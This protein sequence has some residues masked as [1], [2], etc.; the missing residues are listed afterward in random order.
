MRIQLSCTTRFVGPRA[1]LQ[2]DDVHF[3]L[4]V[5]VGFGDEAGDDTQRAA[6]ACISLPWNAMGDDVVLCAFL[7]V[8]GAVPRA[9]GV[10]T[11]PAEVL[12]EFGKEL[13][14]HI[15]A[16]AG[17]LAMADPRPK[18]A[19]A[20]NPEVNDGVTESTDAALVWPALIQTLANLPPPLSSLCRA[21]WY[22]KCATGNF[23][24]VTLR[25]AVLFLVPAQ[26]K[27]IK[28]ELWDE[29]TFV[30]QAPAAVTGAKCEPYQFTY[31]AMDATEASALTPGIDLSSLTDNV[32]AFGLDSYWLGAV[33]SRGT[34]LES[35][36][37]QVDKAMDADFQVK[38][39]DAS[40]I[41][42]LIEIRDATLPL[43]NERRNAL[44]AALHAF[45]SNIAGTDA[46]P[47]S[48]A[49]PAAHAKWER[50]RRE[51]IDGILLRLKSQVGETQRDRLRQVLQDRCSEWWA[52]VLIND[53]LK[54]KLTK[55][56]LLFKGESLALRDAGTLALP[57]LDHVLPLESEIRP[58]PVLPGEGIDFHVGSESNRLVHENEDNADQQGHLAEIES[59]GVLVRRSAR[60]ESL[61]DSAWRLVTAGV[62]VIDPHGT[63]LTH[64]AWGAVP[65]E[66]DLSH[67]NFAVPRG[68]GAAF[69]DGVLRNDHLYL[70]VPLAAGTALAFVHDRSEFETATDGN[71]GKQ[72]LAYLSFER[73]APIK[74]EVGP[75]ISGACAAPPLRYGDWY[76]IAG[77]VTDR[78]GGLPA[79]MAGEMPWQ[80]DFRKLPSLLPQRAPARMQFRRRVP[81]GEINILPGIGGL[82]VIRDKQ[83]K[84]DWPGLPKGVTLRARE[85]LDAKHGGSDNG[86]SLLLGNGLPGTLDDHVFSAEPPR[87]DEHT[88]QRWLMPAIGSAD[89][90][91]ELQAL[92]DE[93]TRIF[94]ARDK[95]VEGDEDEVR[96]TAD[97]IIL[98]QQLLP[99]DPAVSLVMVR[100]TRV[101][102]LERETLQL[103][104][105]PR[106]VSAEL[107]FTWKSCPI[108]CRRPAIPARSGMLDVPLAE[109]HFACIEFLPAVERDVFE[110]RMDAQALAG[111]FDPKPVE[112]LGGTY[113]LFNPSRVLVEHATRRMPAAAD[114]YDAFELRLDGRGAV[115]AAFNADAAMPNLQFVDRF[116]LKRQRW[117]WRNV[118]LTHPSI[119]DASLVSGLPRELMYPRTR[120]THENVHRFDVLATVDRGLVDRGSVSGAMPRGADSSI[121][122]A[123]D[124]FTDDR[125]AMSSADYLRFG[126][127]VRSRYAG[128]FGKEDPNVQAS[129]PGS[130]LEPGGLASWRRIVARYRGSEAD[131][132]A[133]K[134]LTVLPLTKSLELDPRTGEETTVDSSRPTPHVALL[135]ESWFREYGQGEELEARVVLVRREIGD[136]ADDR[137]PFAIGP[138]PDHYLTAANDDQDPPYYRGTM[139]T[140]AA[141]DPLPMFTLP[142]F[143]P[144]GY[145]LDRSGNEALA[146]ATAFVIFP[147][148]DVHPHWVMHVQFRRV[149]RGLHAKDDAGQGDVEVLKGPWSDTHPL[150]T[151]PDSAALCRAT[152]RNK[153]MRLKMRKGEG[154][155]F[156]LT[157]EACVLDLHPY[158]PEVPPL[159]QKQYRYLLIVGPIVSDGGRGVDIML[160]EHAFWLEDAST[161]KSL[162]TGTPVIDGQVIAGRI[163][164]VVT[165]GRYDPGQAPIDAAQSMRSLFRDHLLSDQG[166]MPVN[167]AHGAIRRI[168]RQFIVLP[169]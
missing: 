151:L 63:E 27:R 88:L 74:A 45:A 77:F 122:A 101:D 108:H 159:V 68:L 33:D 13:R 24:E 117:A 136:D 80:I 154:G 72:R 61:E 71:F 50:G 129:G 79:E 64:R 48:N 114:L 141:E 70:G 83:V 132:K 28:S 168:S 102:E 98:G 35:V 75:A 161:A 116:E 85:W 2:Q 5:A 17:E 164:E 26:F 15:N 73:V 160:P 30:L 165:N 139:S 107:P 78:A 120:D 162:G 76:E 127:K 118:P 87:L 19:W 125:D 25:D 92:R 52:S 86:P 103:T 57:L 90:A 149:L 163:L 123:A 138:L 36:D 1:S 106:E 29:Q 60:A 69:V 4:Q 16:R 22:G 62:P 99:H 155:R 91:A 65:G 67:G 146:N 131:I 11:I 135:D 113:I 112:Y 148:E 7:A 82:V 14:A 10:Q 58:H 46:Q 66:P 40:V 137:R 147:P 150:Q 157:P 104:H 49:P 43:L 38:A 84:A 54:E 31:K 124:I 109:G 158:G 169:V 121:L 152:D 133:L 140:D 95:L 12:D 53:D 9:V 134:I 166:A 143:G 96:E 55:S 153:D 44:A 142:A 167:D 3:A 51:R 119:K 8:P 34:T 144:F 115:I 89:A 21:T 20:V 94:V 6:A 39:I 81:V 105:L 156:L 56:G 32:D 126:L 59:V 97:A 128:V 100:I 111:L 145:S 41:E 23:D 42:P 93:M 47:A 37:Q 130:S 110:A 18:F